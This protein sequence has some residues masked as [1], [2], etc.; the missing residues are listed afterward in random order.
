MT[1]KILSRREK[2]LTETMNA[3]SQ[4]TELAAA[5]YAENRQA[6]EYAENRHWAE[7]AAERNFG[8]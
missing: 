6:A 4:A 1:Y 2:T 7:S 5:E 3:V 8:A